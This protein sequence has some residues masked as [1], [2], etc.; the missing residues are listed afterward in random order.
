MQ[1]EDNLKENTIET[2]LSHSSIILRVMTDLADSAVKEM[3]DLKL[4][5]EIRK[6]LLS[7]LV[8]IDDVF[9]DA[10]K[11]AAL[12]MILELHYINQRRLNNIASYD[13]SDISE[14]L[15]ALNKK[16]GIRES[17]EEIITEETADVVGDHLEELFFTE[18]DIGKVSGI[19]PSR[20]EMIQYLNKL[21]GYKTK[22]QLYEIIYKNFGDGCTIIEGDTFTITARVRLKDYFSGNNIEWVMNEIE[23]YCKSY[24]ISSKSI[25]IDL[26]GINIP[27]TENPAVRLLYKKKIGKVAIER[28]EYHKIGEPYYEKMGG[29][30]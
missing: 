5:A 30:L 10:H 4:N 19:R 22:N 18:E 17:L 13:D 29:F 21:F 3:F 12:Q 1:N 27:E 25:A 26:D 23:K 14:L 6:D 8:K 11:K 2:Y 24:N 16:I 20:T 9:D 15:L 7:G 28:Y